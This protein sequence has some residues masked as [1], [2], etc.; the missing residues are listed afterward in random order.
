MRAWQAA[1]GDGH[2]ANE[3]TMLSVI[4]YGFSLMEKKGQILKLERTVGE[5]P[6][7]RLQVQ[8]IPTLTEWV[9]A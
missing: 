2:S 6:H 7:D 3:S 9:E 8:Y 5:P 4:M 1:A